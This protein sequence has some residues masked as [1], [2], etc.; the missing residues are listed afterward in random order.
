M[1]LAL[2]SGLESGEESYGEKAEEGTTQ[3]IPSVG[4][5]FEL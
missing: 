3:G 5:T 4:L 2:A 1:L